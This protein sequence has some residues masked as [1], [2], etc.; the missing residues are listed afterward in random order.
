MTWKRS[1]TIVCCCFLPGVSFCASQYS[2]I[3]LGVLQQGSFSQ[4]LAVNDRGQVVG[5]AGS[6][7]TGHAFLWDGA[8]KDIHPQGEI[9]ASAAAAINSSGTVA[10]TA[11]FKAFRYSNGVSELLTP[12][13]DKAMSFATGISESGA[14]VGGSFNSGSP[15]VATV[16]SPDNTA[17]SPVGWINGSEGSNG[18]GINDYGDIAGDCTLSNL[19]KACYFSS[20]WYWCGNQ[21]QQ[22]GL[23]AV[24]QNRWAVGRLDGAART[25]ILVDLSTNIQY[26]LAFMVGAKGAQA[27]GINNASQIVG[28]ADMYAGWPEGFVWTPKDGMLD[29][30]NLLDQYGHENYAISD[31]HSVNSLGMIAATANKNGQQRA[32]LLVPSTRTVAPKSYQTLLGEVTSGTVDSLGAPDGDYLEICK[33]FVP[34]MNISPIQVEFT[35]TSPVAYPNMLDFRTIGKTNLAGMFT[36][37]VEFFNWSLHSYDG[38]I[39]N[40]IGLGSRLSESFATATLKNP[41]VRYVD[42]VSQTIKAKVSIKANGFVS[43]PSWCVRL[44]QAV[45]LIND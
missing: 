20:G 33:S 37:K 27:F 22:G 23:N 4:A 5:V 40:Q 11:T 13:N 35:A 45:W 2:V 32:V 30:N 25:A 9:G 17:G 26:P 44:D 21:V 29:L 18:Y 28:S 14:I 41:L 1:A 39:Y 43:S 15:T 6:S 36:Q 3:D 19:S 7:G 16:W 38:P 24:A 10:L 31:A 12:A 34:N 42:P 8:M